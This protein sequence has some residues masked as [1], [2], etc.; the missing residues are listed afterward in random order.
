MENIY[1]TNYYYNW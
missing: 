1:K